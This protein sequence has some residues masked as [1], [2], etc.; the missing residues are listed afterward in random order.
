MLRLASSGYFKKVVFISFKFALS[1]GV[2]ISTHFSILL[3]FV[4]NGLK[5][6]FCNPWLI[7]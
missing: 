1:K 3:I 5:N 2:F 7:L 4:L 6:P